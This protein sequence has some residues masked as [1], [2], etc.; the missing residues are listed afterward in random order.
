MDIDENKGILSI[1]YELQV[2]I[3]KY[4]NNEEYKNY[5]LTCRL[6][7]QYVPSENELSVRRC[8]MYEEYESIQHTNTIQWPWW[9]KCGHLNCVKYMFVR[10]GL[11]NIENREDSFSY[12]ILFFASEKGLMD[13]IV[14][15][16]EEIGLT[17][18]E[19]SEIENCTIDDDCGKLKS[20]LILSANNGHLNIVKYLFEKGGLGIK[21]IKEFFKEVFVD[22]V[23][24]GHLNVIKYFVEEI[25]ISIEDIRNLNG[26]NYAIRKA[27]EKGHLDIVKYLVE[28]VGINENDI[29]QDVYYSDAITIASINGHLNI[30][31]YYLEETK[32][33]VRDFHPEY[34]PF[35]NAF[36]SD[37]IQIVEYFIKK[38]KES[39]IDIVD[40]IRTEGSITL[41]N[42]IISGR[43]STIDYFIE[44]FV[45]DKE[46][47]INNHHFL[48][49]YEAVIRGYLNVMKYLIEVV[50]LEFEESYSDDTKII[51]HV[52]R[53]GHLDILKYFIEDL[54][55]DISS[56]KNDVIRCS[57][58][59]GEI[60]I[61]EYLISNKS[62]K[63]DL[64]DIRRADKFNEILYKVTR[65]GHLN[66]IK[67]FVEKVGY[68]A[69]KIHSNDNYI[70]IEAILNDD[71]RI[72]RYLI[73]DIG[74]YE[75]KYLEKLKSLYRNHLSISINNYLTT[76]IRKEKSKHLCS[77]ITKNGK[78]CKR[79]INSGEFCFIHK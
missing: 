32:L 49:L 23:S 53:E 48:F 76:F 69:K 29:Y 16:I 8:G 6:I 9:W 7:N 28:I 24:N 75:I 15:L 72:V 74:E 2:Q 68:T 10:E 38:F 77:G 66:V 64:K 57:L 3:K 78:Q 39:D 13:I 50:G 79:K 54:N 21:D 4:L 11:Y 73:E 59:N 67:F 25:G 31:R 55:I 46:S 71:I 1:P 43:I 27:S 20:S 34:D 19:I 33:N 56:I 36:M 44:K 65:F 30:V 58:L 5:D 14:Y 51:F 63:I 35:I 37:Q 41:L 12:R 70:L 22:T 40:I 52:I 18:E 17:F 26:E 61:L 62:S 60:E 42:L 45:V 47:I